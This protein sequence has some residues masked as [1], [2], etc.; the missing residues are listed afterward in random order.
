MPLI[1]D[2]A[3]MYDHVSR[4]MHL[5]HPYAQPVQLEADLDHAVEYSAIL[6]PSAFH[7]ACERFMQL[8]R[9]ART[10]EKADAHLLA[11]RHTQHVKG[12]RPLFTALVETG[13]R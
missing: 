3:D 2:S 13:L 6:G 7:F 10:S 4:A 9:L 5:V 8:R 1:P 11:Q 12:M